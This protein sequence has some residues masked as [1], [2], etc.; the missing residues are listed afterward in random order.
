MS[1]ACH[2]NIYIYNSLALYIYSL[3]IVIYIYIDDYILLEIRYI[4]PQIYRLT[5]TYCFFF[6]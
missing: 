5:N 3:A 2:G 4:I 6:K 1:F